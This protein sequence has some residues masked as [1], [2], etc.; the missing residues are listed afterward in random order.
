[1][2]KLSHKTLDNQSRCAEC[3][4]GKLSKV[5]PLYYVAKGIV[6]NL[7]HA[8]LGPIDE[9]NS[10]VILRHIPFTLPAFMIMIDADDQHTVIAQYCAVTH[11]WL[12][13]GTAKDK[14][15]L[16]PVRL[17]GK[18]SASKTVKASTAAVTSAPIP[19]VKKSLSSL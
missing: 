16:V 19:R 11:N 6:S 7:A 4:V 5:R 18:S 9:R 17:S 15:D 12:M 8:E 2:P 10:K 13:E 14:A 3:A 1:M